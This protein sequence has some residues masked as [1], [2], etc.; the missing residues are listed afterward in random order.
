MNELNP[1]EFQNLKLY[2]KSLEENVSGY[3]TPY[4]LVKL[5]EVSPDLIPSVIIKNLFSNTKPDSEHIIIRS[6]NEFSQNI[7][8]FCLRIESR[9]VYEKIEIAFEI[10][11][12]IENSID[13]QQALIW[14]YLPDEKSYDDFYD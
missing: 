3:L 6:I 13:Y 7:I 14:E 11:D 2:L 5:V 8:S 1:K 10:L 12:L 9:T 4:F